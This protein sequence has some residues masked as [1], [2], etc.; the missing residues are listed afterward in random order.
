MTHEEQLQVLRTAQRKLSPIPD[1]KWITE[2]FCD[3]YGNC[4]G[5]GHLN[6]L[7]SESIGV[8]S[9]FTLEVL[10]IFGEV[11]DLTFVGV[12]DGDEIRY[13][14]PTPK[15]RVLTAIRDAIALVQEQ[16]LKSK[17]N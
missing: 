10:A 12:N 1:K 2:S 4:C 3:M 16:I 13:Q 7:T 17:N 8:W 11:L 14:Q 15:G 5:G 9:S 6:R